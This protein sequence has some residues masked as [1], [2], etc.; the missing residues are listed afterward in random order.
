MQKHAGVVP[1]RLLIRAGG[2]E[3]LIETSAGVLPDAL[4]VQSIEAEYGKGS[5]KVV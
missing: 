1:L 5:V 4:F 3:T 2:A